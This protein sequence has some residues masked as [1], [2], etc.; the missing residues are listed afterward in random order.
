MN[1]NRSFFKFTVYAELYTGAPFI[2]FEN[3][4]YITI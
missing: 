4:T 3:P 1:L 2:I